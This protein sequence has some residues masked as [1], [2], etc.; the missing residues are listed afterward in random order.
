MT[1]DRPSLA[2]LSRRADAELTLET[3][4]EALRRNLFTP[5]ARALAGAVHGLYGH[6]DRIKDQLFPQT[7]DEDT[8]LNIHVPLELPD[9]RNSATSAS[10]TVLITGTAGMPVDQSD[11]L[12][13]SDGMLYSFTAGTTVGSDGTVLASVVCQT[14]SLAGNTEPG[15]KLRFSNPVDGVNGEVVVQSPGLSGGT[16]IEDIEDLRARVVEARAKSEGVGNTA[17]W[18]RW[19]KEISGVTRAWAAPKLVGAGSMT[20]FFVRDDDA[21]IFPDANEQATVLAHLEAT[22]TTFGEIFAVSP[23]DKPINFSI[24]LSPDTAEIRA[25]V[26]AAL[27]GVISLEGSPVKR[28]SSGLTALPAE[29]VTIPKTHLDAAA[30]NSSGEWDHA[31]VEPAGD[32]VCAIGELATMGTITW[33]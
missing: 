18:E 12:T 14:P 31:I 15:A 7:C 21:S 6:Q 9:G 25:A 13:R 11:T 27:A 19:A 8:L 16:D 10:G 17:D 30:S 23:T 1:I 3:A 33:L 4:S 29:G 24:S 20:V 28:D 2:E 26:T 5:L 32:I 22:G